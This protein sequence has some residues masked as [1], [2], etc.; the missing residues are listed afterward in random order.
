MI[1]Y[2]HCEPGAHWW[3][4][5]E[6]ALPDEAGAYC[7]YCEA[8]GDASNGGQQRAAAVRGGRGASPAADR[9]LATKRNGP[10]PH[11]QAR[12]GPPESVAQY[13]GYT[14]RIPR[15]RRKVAL[16]WQGC[17]AAG[18][19]AAAGDCAAPTR[20]RIAGGRL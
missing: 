6:R 17:L 16:R 12:A 20:V 4:R 15:R 3:I 14:D 2:R 8:V 19:A 5:R 7:A 11:R 18:A 9:T 10:T 1:T 13:D